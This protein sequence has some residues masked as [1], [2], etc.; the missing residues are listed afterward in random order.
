MPEAEYAWLPR[1]SI[2]TFEELESLARI[3]AGLGVRKLRLTG[4]EPL[5]RHDLASL[6]TRLA[7]LPGIDEIALTTNG[8]LL[9]RDADAL[10]RAGLRRVT[11]SL[12]TL[13]PVRAREFARVDRHSDILDGIAAARE[14][15]F[16]VKLNAVV[17]RGY[18]DDELDRLLDYARAAGAELRFV[19][20]MDVGGATDWSMDAVVSRTEMLQRLQSSRGVIEALPGRGAAPAERFQLADG[21]VF[22]IIASTTEP[23][24]RDCDRARLT[25]DGHWLTCLYAAEG[26]DL[27]EP[28]RTGASDS[29]IAALITAAWTGRTDRGA[30]ER[31]ALPDRSALYQLDA[32]RSDPRREMHTRGG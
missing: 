2:L 10:R 21:T 24:C 9:R 14:A 5:L 7:G 16:Q 3:F 22:G 27:R 20:Y 17:I 18:N 23:F 11:V 6:V 32:L 8:L 30:E 4:G 12:D 15:G 19:E 1:A 25:A 31:R 26:L 29:A 28:L 13:D